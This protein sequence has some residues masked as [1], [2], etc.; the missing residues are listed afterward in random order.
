MDTESK[1]RGREPQK[2]GLV[3]MVPFS[4]V[5]WT[6]AD[7]NL[8]DD[9]LCVRT[10]I[11]NV[12]FVGEP[13][14]SSWI[15]VDAGVNGFVDNI[16]ETAVQRY[17][18]VPPRAIILTHGHFDHVGSLT[19]LLEQW[20]VPVY[21]HQAELPYLTGEADYPPADPSVGGGLMAFISPLYPHHPID[22]RGHVRPLPDHGVIPDRPEWRWLHTPGHTVGHVSL[23]RQSDGTVIVGDAFITVKQESAWAVLTQV[24]EVHGPPAYF[25]TDWNAAWQSVRRLA[26]LR[27]SVAVTGHGLPMSGAGLRLGLETLAADFDKLAIPDQGRYVH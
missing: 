2:H 22:L 12:C 17:G 5:A 4:T 6:K 19:P 13:M 18:D 3:A 9:L 26:S 10:A 8:P 24:Q 20:D 11:A 21:A 7:G 1:E 16:V 15:L 25:T 23:Y 27:P 14:S